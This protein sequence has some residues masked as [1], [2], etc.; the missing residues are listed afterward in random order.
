[1]ARYRTQTYSTG[2]NLADD[3]ETEV[4]VVFTY[5]PGAPEQGPT[6]DC[7][8]T[9]ADPDVIEIQSVTDESGK[10]VELQDAEEERLIDWI[11]GNPQ[12]FV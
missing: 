4:T 7:G 12:V 5:T 1:M 10:A 2:W 8:G 9:P 6:Y 3:Q 11:A